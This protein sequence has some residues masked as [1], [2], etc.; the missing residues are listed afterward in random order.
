MDIERVRHA[1]RLVVAE[2]SNRLAG[3]VDDHAATRTARQMFFQLA[4]PLALGRT[5]EVAT[6][7]V[8]DVTTFFVHKTLLSRAF[9]FD[10]PRDAKVTRL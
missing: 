2:E 1:G 8:E 9:P 10:G 6:E 7:D 4:A 5:I 3:G